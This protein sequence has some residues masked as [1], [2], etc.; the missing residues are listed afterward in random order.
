[1]LQQIIIGDIFNSRV[2]QLCKKLMLGDSLTS[3]EVVNAAGLPFTILKFNQGHFYSDL[4]LIHW[5]VIRMVLKAKI[6]IVKV[7]VVM[8]K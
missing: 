3:M 4:K 7:R 8:K 1:M 5:S 6:I 2:V